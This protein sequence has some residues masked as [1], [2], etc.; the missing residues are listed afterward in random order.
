MQKNEENRLT[1]KDTVYQQRP[2]IPP[3]SADSG[4]I[5]FYTLSEMI[6]GT[7]Q[8]AA[9][10]DFRSSAPRTSEHFPLKAFRR[11]YDIF[12]E[13][14]CRKSAAIKFFALFCRKH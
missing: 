10:A 6:F 11:S 2:Q 9:L 4:G 12:P 7:P 1:V 13:L 3:K 14:K 8:Y 5:L